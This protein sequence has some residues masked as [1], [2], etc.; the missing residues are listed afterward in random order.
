MMEGV[1]CVGGLGD[2]ELAAIQHQPSPARAELG[3]SSLG[4]G[5]LELLIAAQVIVDGLCNGTSGGSCISQMPHLSCP[6]SS[7]ETDCRV[8]GR[9]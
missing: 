6:C 2:L 8:H 5:L 3:G 7:Q 1:L 9:G 4:E